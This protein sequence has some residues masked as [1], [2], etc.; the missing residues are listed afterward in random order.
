MFPVGSS[1]VSLSL[2]DGIFLQSRKLAL[3]ILQYLIFWTPYRECSLHLINK[4][5]TRYVGRD[6]TQP[7]L[8]DENYRFL[9]V[10]WTTMP[11]KTLNT[12]IKLFL[13]EDI[14]SDL[15][16]RGPNNNR[17]ELLYS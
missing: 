4:A 9:L 16:T 5:N 12:Q 8:V 2:M 3:I 7:Q 15:T 1:L 17:I 10:I 13:K 6:T 11:V 14:K